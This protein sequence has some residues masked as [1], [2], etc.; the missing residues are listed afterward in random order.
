M[1]VSMDT[2]DGTTPSDNMS[3]NGTNSPSL[4]N[5]G[6]KPSRPP[7]PSRPPPPTPQRTSISASP[8]GV[9]LN[10]SDASVNVAGSSVAPET[11]PSSTAV[12]VSRQIAPVNMDNQ[13]FPPVTQGA[14]PPGWEQR[15]DQHGRVYFVDHVAKRTTWDPPEPLPAG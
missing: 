12:P 14:L 1:T 9:F 10:N 2:A 11:N 5:G 15:V 8:N 13:R 4:S 6:F 7:R 3:T